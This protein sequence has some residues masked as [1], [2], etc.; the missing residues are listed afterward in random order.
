VTI[1]PIANIYNARD[2]SETNC[3]IISA[4]VDTRRTRNDRITYC[5]D[6]KYEYEFDGE[7]YRSEKYSFASDLGKKEVQKTVSYYYNAANPVCFVNPDKPS[8]SVLER[9]FHMRPSWRLLPLVVLF[10]SL[11][12]LFRLFSIKSKTENNRF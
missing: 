1:R 5:V 6:I 4:E 12:E 8:E 9:G 7:S 2:W 11:W 10:Y 3:K